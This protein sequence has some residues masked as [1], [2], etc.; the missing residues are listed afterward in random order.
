MHVQNKKYGNFVFTS[1]FIGKCATNFFKNLRSSSLWECLHHM[2]IW[3]SQNGNTDFFMI[4]VWLCRFKLPEIESFTLGLNEVTLSYCYSGLFRP[5]DS[6]AVFCIYGAYHSSLTSSLV[7]HSSNQWTALKWPLVP[8]SDVKQYS[9]TTTT[10]TTTT[11]IILR[12][13]VIII[14]SYS[15]G[16]HAS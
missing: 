5:E 10:T 16:L 6:G 7:D 15:G 9:T 3:R 12:A 14:T 4:L 1:R 8:Q 11:T 2:V 13:R